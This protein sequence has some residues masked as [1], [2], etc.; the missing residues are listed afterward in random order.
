MW[1]SPCPLT[2]T[3]F[4]INPLHHKTCLKIWVSKGNPNAVFKSYWKASQEGG[5]LGSLLNPNFLLPHLNLLLTLLS[6]VHPP[7][8]NKLTLRRERN[9]RARRQWHLEDLVLPLKKRPTGQLSNREPVMPP[10]ED[11]KRATFNCLSPKHGSQPLCL[12]VN[13]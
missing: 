5:K 4:L 6:H 8:L 7:G 12:V 2:T 9:Q 11:Q 13:P 3:K 10:V 1:T